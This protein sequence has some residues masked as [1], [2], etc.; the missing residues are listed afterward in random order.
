MKDELSGHIM[1][2]FIGLRS[3]T[4]KYLKKN[5]DENKNAK[6]RKKGVIKRKI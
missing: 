2:E 1:K 5:Y 4:Y 6:D 3:K